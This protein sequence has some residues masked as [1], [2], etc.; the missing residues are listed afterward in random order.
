MSDRR[1][2]PDSQRFSMTCVSSHARQQHRPRPLGSLGPGLLLCA[3]WLHAS[4]ALAEGSS[5]KSS[6]GAASSPPATSS[7]QP[8]TGD[9]NPN[10]PRVARPL[11]LDLTTFSANP[12]LESLTPFISQQTQLPM[13]SYPI[14][15]SANPT[16]G[17][18]YHWLF[19]N[20]ETGCPYPLQPIEARLKA[21]DALL[22]EVELDT[23]LALLQ[24]TWEELPCTV[25]PI[26]RES[27]RRLFYL[28]GITY[29]YNSDQGESQRAF[30]EAI[31]VEPSL[32]PISGYAPEVNDAYLQAARNLASLEPVKLTVDATLVGSGLY[33]DGE[34]VTAGELSLRPGRHSAQRFNNSGVARTVGFEVQ[35]EETRSLSSLLNLSPPDSANYHR[36]MLRT[37]MLGGRLSPQELRALSAYAQLQGHPYLL[38]VLADADTPGG[39]KLRVLVPG[40]GLVDKVPTKAEVPPALDLRQTLASPPSTA[41]KLP[42]SPSDPAPRKGGTA[43][44]KLPGEEETFEARLVL[45]PRTY[46]ARP[47]LTLQPSMAY[48]LSRLLSAEFSLYYGMGPGNGAGPQSILGLRPA[49]SVRSSSGP[50]SLRATGGLNVTAVDVLVVDSAPTLQLQ[51][52]PEL[53][54]SALY[55]VQSDLD[56]G[57]Q[58]GVG[59]APGL[60]GSV[61]LT[62]LWQ[63][64]LVIQ[65]SF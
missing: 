36:E 61:G 64:G 33:I 55:S 14:M 54:A 39:L 41:K 29:L 22:V 12:R 38:F 5:N 43:R 42:T 30:L 27:L 52:M 11:V 37:S 23:A 57:F 53:E 8:A 47:F 15:T 45:G 60:A 62:T 28:E 4:P 49:V 59:L 26:T 65:T 19:L 24:K 48:H 46:K 32:M 9:N 34:P 51:L 20:E 10:A 35:R 18:L 6:S 3:L 44:P 31:A 58:L 40:Q 50:L 2:N 21:V 17:D 63:M 56:A 13:G 16:F 1:P 25:T 7:P